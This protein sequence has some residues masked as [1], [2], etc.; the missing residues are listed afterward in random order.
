MVEGVSSCGNCG[1]TFLSQENLNKHEERCMNKTYIF[2]CKY[3]HRKF[4]REAHKILHQ[5]NCSG[6]DEEIERPLKQRKID[7]FTLSSNVQTGGSTSQRQAFEE[8]SLIAS[9]LN[10]K[11]LTY[12]IKFNPESREDPMVNLENSLQRYRFV[13]EKELRKRSGVKYYFTLS[14]IFHQSKD[15]SIVTDVPVSFRTEVFTALNMEK[16]DLHL[17]VTMKQLQQKIDQFQRNGSGWVLD[18]FINIDIGKT[19]IFYY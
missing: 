9:A 19:C 12:R 11:A 10:K 4:T 8:P 5:Q 18:H 7:E 14:T 16:F 6:K 2:H 17:K 1:S 3:C 13:T 15:K